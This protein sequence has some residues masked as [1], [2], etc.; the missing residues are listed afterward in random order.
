MFLPQV[1]GLGLEVGLELWAPELGLHSPIDAHQSQPKPTV[2][3]WRDTNL[4]VVTGTFLKAR[5]NVPAV[6]H[7]QHKANRALLIANGGT[8]P[9]SLYNNYPNGSSEATGRLSAESSNGH[10]QGAD[11]FQIAQHRMMPLPLPC[12]HPHDPR[13]A[14]MAIL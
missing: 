12:P 13:K 11:P 14:Y 1:L 10:G 3:T 7:H 2:W 4:R 6:C 5:G 9:I 8:I